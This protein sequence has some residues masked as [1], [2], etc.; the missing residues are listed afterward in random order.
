MLLRKHC[1]AETTPDHLRRWPPYWPDISILPPLGCCCAKCGGFVWWAAGGVNDE[2]VGWSC[3][4]CNP[5]EPG[6]VVKRVRS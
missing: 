4:A 6:L 2:A 3:E 1:P 5:P